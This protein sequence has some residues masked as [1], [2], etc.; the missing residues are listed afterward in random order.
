MNWFA[1]L[2]ASVLDGGN[3]FGA[4][5]AIAPDGTV[6]GGGGAALTGYSIVDADGL[7]DAVAKT[8]GCPVLSS[9]GTVDVYETV[10]VG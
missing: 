4:S 10:D 5:R 7:D 1:G 2:G 6:R 8:R 3:P 9:G